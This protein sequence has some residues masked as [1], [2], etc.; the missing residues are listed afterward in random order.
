MPHV[1]TII[2]HPHPDLNCPT[3]LLQL[4][5]LEPTNLPGQ[6]YPPPPCTLS[7]HQ[8]GSALP[9]GTGHPCVGNHYGPHQGS[10]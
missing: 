3:V 8:Q 7:V 1:H 5:E 6:P 4:E 9:G 2:P 10:G